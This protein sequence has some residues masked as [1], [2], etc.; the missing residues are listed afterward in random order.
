MSLFGVIGVY[1]FKKHFSELTVDL[2]INMWEY[3]LK[4]EITVHI[5]IE[6]AQR[7]LRFTYWCDRV[8]A[9][10]RGTLQSLP[11]RPR[12]GTSIVKFLKD[13]CHL[14][15]TPHDILDLQNTVTIYTT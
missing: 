4:T 9:I 1:Y 6:P 11:L 10:N 15:L 2:S 5:K 7:E 3:C 8:I 12:E 13:Q 14:A